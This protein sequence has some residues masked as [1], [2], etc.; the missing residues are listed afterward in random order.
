LAVTWVFQFVLYYAKTLRRCFGYNDVCHSVPVV[1]A[2]WLQN[3]P[4]AW[5]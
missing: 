1:V 4:D 5:K 3:R 2:T